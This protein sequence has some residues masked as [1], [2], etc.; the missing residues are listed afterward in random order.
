[1]DIEDEPHARAEPHALTPVVTNETH[2]YALLAVIASDRGPV[3]SAAE[4]AKIAERDTLARDHY[5]SAERSFDHVQILR[6]RIARIREWVGEHQEHEVYEADSTQPEECTDE[7]IWC[8]VVEILE[9]PE[10]ARAVLSGGQ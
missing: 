6:G 8:P 3:L 10:F 1:M 7:C 2:A 5:E 9:E 4:N